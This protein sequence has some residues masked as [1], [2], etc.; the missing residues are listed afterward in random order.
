MKATESSAGA[1]APE[2]SGSPAEL[3]LDRQ[4]S[5]LTI[6]WADG[7]RSRLTASALRQACRCAQCTARR[8]GG[9]PAIDAVSVTIAAVE[10]IG[11]YAVNIAF[12]DRHARGVYPW[13]LLRALA[14]TP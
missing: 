1:A 7:T 14:V 5:A 6:E 8:A 3:Q 11:S 12:S 13:A 2:P 10:P 9:K 4:R